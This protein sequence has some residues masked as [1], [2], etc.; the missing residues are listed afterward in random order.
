MPVSSYL[1]LNEP[2]HVKLTTSASEHTRYVRMAAT[3]APYIQSG[4]GAAPTLGW[5]SNE[6]SA[7]ARLVAPIY[8]ILNG[9]L[10]NRR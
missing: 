10:P 6:V 5:K 1:E 2:R 9:I 4:V 3:V 7:Q 8:G